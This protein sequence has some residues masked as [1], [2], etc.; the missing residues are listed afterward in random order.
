MHVI[1]TEKHA[2]PLL[3][4]KLLWLLLLSFFLNN[5]H[6]A[7]IMS[8]NELQKKIHMQALRER[9]SKAGGESEEKAHLIGIARSK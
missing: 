8:T 2:D 5:T 3:A 1:I 6:T 9:E 7:K 4:D